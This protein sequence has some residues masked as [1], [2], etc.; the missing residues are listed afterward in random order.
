MNLKSVKNWYKSGD[1]K[2]AF[3][4]GLDASVNDVFTEIYVPI[5]QVTSINDQGEETCDYGLYNVGL[6]Y[7]ELCDVYSTYYGRNYLVSDTSE[8]DYINDLG[9]RIKNVVRKNWY[10][11]LKL[12]EL[13]GYLYNPIWNVDGIELHGTADFEGDTDTLHNPAGS[14]ETGAHASFPPTTKHYVNPYDS[15]ADTDKRLESVDETSGKTIQNFDSYSEVNSM[16]HHVASNIVNTAEEG[17]E[18]NLET[19]AFAISYK[20]NV[21]G[22]NAVGPDRY[23]IE[24]NARQGNIGVTKTQELIAAE[25]ENLKF[26]L[27]QVFFDDINEQILVGLYDI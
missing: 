3:N 5:R 19:Q 10:K 7:S 23:F 12:I 26:N 1:L 20:D 14:I 13:M 24:K 25:R 6:T 17:E 15:N 16:I 8:S 9:F 21:F 2:Q 11:Y 22:A 18:P 4:I 27:F